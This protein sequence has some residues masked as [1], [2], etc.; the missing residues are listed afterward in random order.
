VIG[1]GWVIWDTCIREPTR[2]PSAHLAITGARTEQNLY[3]AELA[4]LAA[5]AKALTEI[6]KAMRGWPH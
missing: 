1:I 5:I 3:T 6:V 4:E 2:T